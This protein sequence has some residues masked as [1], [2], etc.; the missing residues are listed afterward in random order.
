MTY[1]LVLL[2]LFG[3]AFVSSDHLI[4]PKP[5]QWPEP[6]Y[7]FDRNPLSAEKI[8]LGR[9]LFYDPLLSADQ[10][11]SC[12]SCHNPY[13]AFAH[14]DHALSHGIGDRSGNRNAPALFNLAWQKSFMW[15]AAIADLDMQA[16]AP[17][18]H[19]DEMGETIA[20][21]VEKIGR[22]KRYQEAFERAWGSREVNSQRILF[23]LSQFMLS[24]VSSDAKYD[25]VKK[26]NDVFTFQ[27]E[28]GYRLF[29]E[30]CASCHPEP[31][32]SDYRL[33]NNG[34]LP[35]PLLQDA[36][37]ARI[38]H[39][40]EDS[41][42]FKTPSLRNVE[43]TYPYMHDGRFKKLSD[44]IHHYSDGTAFSTSVDDRLKG[45]LH[46]SEKEEVDLVAFLLTLTDKE[47][48]FAPEHQYPA[49]FFNDTSH[50]SP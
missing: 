10:K 5:A 6:A 48:L 36:G 37:H 30:H 34:L 45:G 19:P 42:L 49:E 3:S 44:V 8:Q 7:P 23:S 15:D 43:Y 47:F 46:L 38:S 14:A 13:N 22:E 24:L 50:Q 1:I 25:R 17:I 31:L 18:S 32:F 16:L 29:S 40:R 35:D 9:I 39:K 20:Q 28:K 2:A 11:I 27:E 4:F 21:V 33:H 26:G 41:L 12:A